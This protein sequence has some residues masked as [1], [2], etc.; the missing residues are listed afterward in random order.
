MALSEQP[1]RLL[2]VDDDSEL[3]ELLKQKFEAEGYS[4]TTFVDGGSCLR[5]VQLYG[6][7]HLALIDLE[8]RDM[9]GFELSERLKTLGDV[10]IVFVTGDNTTESVVSGLSRY[11]DDYVVKPFGLRELAVRVHRVLSRMPNFDYT[12]L[13]IIKVNKR[14][15]IDFGQSRLLINNK[16]VALTPIEASIL[17]ILIRNAGRPVLSDTLIARTWPQEEVY[18]EALRVHIHRLRRKIEPDCRNPVHILTERG[19]GYRFMPDKFENVPRGSG[20]SSDSPP[21]GWTYNW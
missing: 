2:V 14:L 16:P 6:L 20:F 4:V 8:L 17:H 7:P 3:L 13:P 9:H 12:C 21:G 10:P 18:E 1:R 11:A 5:H 19:T 15:S